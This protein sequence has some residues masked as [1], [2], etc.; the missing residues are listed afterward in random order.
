MKNV[1]FAAR[2]LAIVA[3]LSLAAFVVTG[4]G[5]DKNGSGDTASNNSGDTNG[6]DTKQFDQG[7]TVGSAK[8]VEVDSDQDF[9]AEEQA[10]IERV[11]EFGDATA[12]QN[13]KKLCNDLL[14]KAAR[15]IGNGDCVGTFEKTGAQL[16]DFKIV[17]KSVDVNKDGK[18]A[19]ATIDV[20]S[21]VQKAQMQQTLPLIKEGGEWRI[22]I[23]GQ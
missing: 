15:K 6:G 17:V 11:G 19:T 22:Q 1:G 14:S 20:S 3:V 5:D 18:T 8:K 4:C 10:I 9:S 13:Y 16:K 23:L 12:D 7:D 2:L 21:N